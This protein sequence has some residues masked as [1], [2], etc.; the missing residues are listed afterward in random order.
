MDVQSVL[1]RKP[2]RKSLINPLNMANTAPDGAPAPC[3]TLSLQCFGA[4]LLPN[5]T[6]NSSQHSDSTGSRCGPAFW[7]GNNN[8]DSLYVAGSEDT[9]I[10]DFQ[11]NLTGNHGTF[12]IPA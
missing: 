7:V 5:Y 1:A 8:E 9:E 3:G 4:I 12:Q 6:S 10:W 11:M 2:K